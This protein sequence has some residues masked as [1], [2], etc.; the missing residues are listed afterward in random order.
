MEAEAVVDENVTG[1]RVLSR[2]MEIATLED[3]G[4]VAELEPAAPLPELDAEP[5]VEAWLVFVA[6]ASVSLEVTALGADVAAA[7]CAWLS[8]PDLPVSLGVDVA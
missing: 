1:W 6:A 5:E 7:S 8:P 3:P 4:L 2:L